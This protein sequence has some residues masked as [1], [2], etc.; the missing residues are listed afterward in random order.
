[1]REPLEHPRVCKRAAKGR[2]A[3]GLLSSNVAG[4]LRVAEHGHTR[5]RVSDGRSIAPITLWDEPMFPHGTENTFGRCT[6][7]E[8]PNECVVEHPLTDVWLNRYKQR[9]V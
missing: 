7:T 2:S 3:E 8:G 4:S 9:T 1:M 6:F 5:H